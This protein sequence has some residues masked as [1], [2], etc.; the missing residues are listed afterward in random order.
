MISSIQGLIGLVKEARL[1]WFLR[2]PDYKMSVAAL[3]PSQPCV[4]ALKQMAVLTWLCDFQAG[5]GPDHRQRSSGPGQEPADSASIRQER[6][7]QLERPLPIPFEN[8][9]ASAYFSA[10]GNLHPTR[11]FLPSR[12]HLNLSP[13]VR[14]GISYKD[15]F[16]SWTAVPTTDIT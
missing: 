2:T 14:I 13:S 6:T 10:P 5:A 7:Q 3:Q 1:L 9:A 8:L 15:I 11:D 16:P 4:S 12:L